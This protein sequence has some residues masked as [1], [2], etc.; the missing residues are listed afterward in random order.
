MYV[1]EGEIAFRLHWED[2]NRNKQE[3]FTSAL[4][5]EQAISEGIEYIR[6]KIYMASFSI[7]GLE[8]LIERKWQKIEITRMYCN[9]R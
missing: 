9:G 8:Q 3:L 2:M 1:P 7:V 4:N 6:N 5:Q